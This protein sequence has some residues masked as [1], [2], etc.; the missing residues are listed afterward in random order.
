MRPAGRSRSPVDFLDEVVLPALFERLDQA[1][2]DF[3]W[4]RT[5]VGWTATN[6]DHTKGLP[7]AP[8][9]ERVVCNR[10]MGF[11]VQG[12]GATSWTAYVAGGAQPTGRDFVEAVRTLAGLAGVDAA[13]LDRELTPEEA[14]AHAERERRQGLLEAFAARAQQALRGDAG[15]VARDYLTGRGFPADPDELADLG[16]GVF[17]TG[18]EV[19]DELVAAGYT[20]DE[21]DRSGLLADGRW[22]GRLVLPWRGRWGYVAT[23][24]ARDLAGTAEEGAKYLYLKDHRKPEAFGLDVALRPDAGGRDHLVLVEGLLDVVALHH[25][26]FR[27]VA[28]LGGSGKLLDAKRWAALAGY[29]VRTATLVLDND[30][31]GREGTLAAVDAAL[32]SDAAPA[33]WV[34]DPAELGTC[35]DPD[36]LVRRDGLDAFRA[37]LDRRRPGS[38]YQLVAALGDVTP[39][40]PDHERRAAVDRFL[41][42][43]GRLRGP[44]AE[45]DREDAL[46]LVADRTGYTLDTLATLAEDHQTRRVRERAER[47]Q[48]ALLADAE[49][50]L[51]EDGP[52]ASL[53][54]LRE[55]VEQLRSEERLR[56][57][58]PVRSVAEEAADHAARL[59]KWRG[60]DFVGLPQR[61]LP[62]LDQATL[63]LRGLMLLA[64]APNVGKTALGVQLGVDVVRHN[65][66][67]CFLFVSLEMTRWDILSRIRSRLAELDWK[68]LVFGSDR[69]R[70]RGRDAAFTP[71]EL[72]R[73]RKAD[74]ELAD[75]GE[76]VL[77]LDERNFPNPTV[78]AVLRRLEDLR[79]AT[80]T[81]RALLLVDYLQVW[82]IPD[83]RARNLRSDL[84]ADKWRIGAMKELR[85][86]AE[87]VAVLVVSEARK[88]S[89][90]GAGAAWGG[91]LA[92]VMGSAR[93]S[94][95]PDAVFLLRPKE[96]A[97]D[98]D[99][100]KRE[101][102]K[103]GLAHHVLRI[104]KGRDGVLREDIDLTFRFR[105]SVFEEG[106]A[107]PEGAGGR[108]W[109]SEEEV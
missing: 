30:P 26:G 81:S 27:N 4:R 53:E 62:T 74:R 9:P 10:P 49:R 89:G 70:G 44:A 13:C 36:E 71:D 108:R 11:L 94:Y 90:T 8:R 56:R 41:E 40:S 97:A 58:E 96:E 98:K 15:K 29:G 52:A 102:Q 105:R 7:G 16:F 21:V 47:D 67:A 50:V 60:L 59:E 78:E 42:V 93:G 57:A 28:A 35:K 32:R 38:G 20:A 87:D 25:R 3:G 31:A 64:A 76:R 55:G 5:A 34:V 17:T 104:A 1:F 84:E 85:D 68:T 12:H 103:A 77:I 22:E 66:D 109:S 100:A 86:G 14:A 80:G 91:D 107:K 88:P 83:A 33:V 39:G 48:K 51:D 79:D 72:G 99:R 19:G 6:R 73:L 106:H 43:D 92:D 61:T 69:H 95:T 45:L 23:V 24:V 37:L 54:V 2:P 18:R 82:P 65:Q 101:L 63:G 46:Q 75:W